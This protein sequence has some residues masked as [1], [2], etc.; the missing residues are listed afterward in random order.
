M[1]QF[2]SALVWFRRDLRLIDHAALYHALTQARAVFCLFVFDTDILAALPAGD[3]RVAFIHES[4]CELRRGLCAAG[5]ALI[6][7]HARALNEVPRV[8]AQLGV[9]AVFFNRDYEPQA[10]ARDQAVADALAREGI[11]FQACKDQAIFDHDDILSG[12]HHPYSVFTPYKRAW[13][14]ALRADNLAAWP[15][16]AHLEALAP[17]PPGVDARLPTLAELGFASAASPAPGGSEAAWAQL[18][19]FEDRLGRYTQEREIPALDS[20]SHLSAH[21]RHGTLSVRTLARSAW[22]QMQSA[23]T[24]D[25]AAT[26]LSELT[27]RDFFFQILHHHPRL[28]EAGHPAFKPEYDEI[29]WEQGENGERLFQAWRDGRTGY[30]LV[31]AAMRQIA[32]T[33]FMHNR[34]RMVVATFLC[35]DL[36]IDWRRGEAYFAEQLID[37][38]LSANNG[39][40]QWASSSGCDAQPYFRIFNPL[41]QS[42]KFDPHGHFIRRFMPE[43]AGLDERD[44]HAPWSAD[45]KTL[46]ERGLVLGGAPGTSSATHYPL[47]IVDHAQARRAALERYAVVKSPRTRDRR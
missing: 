1:P 30:P 5:G 47:P 44:I 26:W 10:K 6:V 17:L 40:W 28:G 8:A 12:A 42:R 37:Y 41:T 46:Q 9:D 3:R 16:E 36:G 31:D 43:L 32:Q 25:G 19:A 34:L 39:N 35:K 11:T 7:R 29:R 4:L 2:D 24:R 38:D 45:S 22:A 18:E 20:T 21:L 15:S 13:N 33:G 27:W 23:E 14:Q